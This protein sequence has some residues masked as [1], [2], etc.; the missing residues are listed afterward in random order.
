MNTLVQAVGKYSRNWL[1]CAH[2]T[3]K[4]FQTPAACGGHNPK[5]RNRRQQGLKPK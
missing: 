5:R 1:G 2:P 3:G 4:F